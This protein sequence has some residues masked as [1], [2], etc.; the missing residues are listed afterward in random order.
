MSMFRM[1]RLFFWRRTGL[2]PYG[3]SRDA[4]VRDALLSDACED[5]K[6]ECYLD[7]AALDYKDSGDA[8]LD[9]I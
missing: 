1:L 4:A 5:E 9:K 6:D 2:L 8:Y 7:D 3:A